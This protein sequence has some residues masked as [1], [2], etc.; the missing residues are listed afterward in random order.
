MK[1]DHGKISWVCLTCFVVQGP[2][3]FSKTKIVSWWLVSLV[4][5]IFGTVF[6]KYLFLNQ[7]AWYC[8]RISDLLGLAGLANMDVLGV[9]A[10]N[11]SGRF[12]NLP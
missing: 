12:K 8:C 4:I 9:S 7:S 2:D 3:P 6:A 5:P 1:P 10:N 11:F